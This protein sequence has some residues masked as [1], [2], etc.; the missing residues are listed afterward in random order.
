MCIVLQSP[1]L[2]CVDDVMS[3]VLTTRVCDIC[4]GSEI[5]LIIG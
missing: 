5:G 3:D 1:I 4:T 2:C